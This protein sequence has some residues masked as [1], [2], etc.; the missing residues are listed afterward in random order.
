MRLGRLL[1]A[2]TVLAQGVLTHPVTAQEAQD[3]LALKDCVEIA[4]KNNA[5]IINARYNVDISDVAVQ[6]AKGALLPRISTSYGANKAVTGPRITGQII[7]PATGQVISAA[8]QSVVSG[9]QSVGANL[10]M[11]IYDANTLSSIAASRAN[12]RATEQTFQNTRLTTVQ[13][14]KQRFFQ[15][16][17]AEKLLNLNKESVRV[18]EES[19]RRAQTM[20]EIGSAPVSDVLTARS[21]LESRKVTVITQQNAVDIAKSNLAFTLGIDVNQPIRLKEDTLAVRPIGMA[22]EQALRR[23][24]DRRPDLKARK[25]SLEQNRRQLEGT[26]SQIRRPTVSLSAGYGWGTQN[27]PFRGIEDLFLQN[28]NYTFGLSIQM[29]IFNGLST[30]NTIRQRKLQYLQ[31]VEQ[32]R[33]DERQVALSVKQA[34]LN[35]DRSRQQIDAENEAVK[36]AEEDFRLAEERYNFGAGTI[37]E[38]LQAQERMFAAKNRYINATYGYQQELANLEAAIGGLEEE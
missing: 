7:D 16:L 28:Y 26:K 31:S 9:S 21:N 15:V 29:P 23:A 4:L 20:Y 5:E 14:V 11:T 27:T 12:H 17:Q 35:L 36:A 33:R 13:T 34:L 37:L 24:L 30:E 38:R 25:F 19:L 1:F 32:L 22:Y 2:L 6:S 18:A 3:S 8:G 10:S